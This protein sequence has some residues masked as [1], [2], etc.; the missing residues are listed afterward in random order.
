VGLDHEVQTR[1]PVLTFLFTDIEGHS[2]LWDQHPDAMSLALSEHDELIAS[3]IADGGGRVVKNAGDGAMAVFA[4]ADRAVAAAV[5]IQRALIARVWPDIGSLRVRMGLNAGS[6]ESR[7]GDFF[8]PEVIRAARL[9]S[10]ANASQIVAS[11]AVVE[12]AR[13]VTWLALGQHQL[14]GFAAPVEIHQVVA[15]GLDASFPA[16]RTVDAH[17]NTLPRFRTAFFG[18]DEEIAAVAELLSRHRLVTL[19][20][21]GG[22]GKTRLAVE[23]AHDQLG[24]YADGVFFADLS[25]VSETDRLWSAVAV[26]LEL[27]LGGAPGAAEEPGQRIARFLAERRALLV[28]DNCEHL[29]DAAADAADQLLDSTRHLRVLATSR[30]GLHLED[31]RMV[32][33]PSL[34]LETDAV[35]MFR[36]RAA[37][38]GEGAVEDEV[39]RDICARL[40]GLPLAIELAAARAGQLGAGEVARRLSDRFELLTGSRRRVPRQRTLEATL[41]WSHDHLSAEEQTA[42]R[43]L[44]VFNGTFSMR[45]AE[46]VT[47]AP[48]ALI[49]PLVDK[50]LVNRGDDGRFRLLETVRAYAE[51]RLVEADEAEM[52]RQAHLDWL[53]DEIGSFSDEEVLLATSDRSDEFVAA[54]MENLYAAL[55]WASGRHE[56]STVARL[57]TYMGLAEGLIGQDSFRPV[58]AVLRECLDNGIDGPLRDRALAGYTA[59]AYLRREAPRE[60]LLRE[61]AERS[62]DRPDGTAVAALTYTANMLDARSRARGDDPGIDLARRLIDTAAT[63]ARELGPQWQTLPVLFEVGLALSGSDWE[64]AAARADEL[65]G[66]RQQGLVGRVSDWALWVEAAA[67]LAV[68]RPLARDEIDRRL[69]TVRRRETSPGAEVHAR[70]F[71]APERTGPRQPMHLDR[72]GLDRSTPADETAVLISVA[73]LAAREGDWHVAAKLLAAGRGGG[74]IF[75]SVAGVALYRLTTPLVKEAL[76]KPVRDALIEEGRELGKSRAVGLAIDWLAM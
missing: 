26:G 7:D 61:A 63:Q 2:T 38:S 46:T 45:A 49:G 4:D 41:D 1:S 65:E 37:A 9:C 56:W 54:E 19:T 11:R 68:G 73:A 71:A 52:A 51:D 13:D 57:A 31:E 43:R 6:A 58:G 40:D 25:A 12:L 14:R 15:D 55:A 44:G 16:L 39:A 67:R 29:L 8:G 33:V 75:S 24:S 21:V 28:L 59:V 27:D 23:I 22:S 70:A 3:L 10:A 72:S 62:L 30:E 20:G 42:F 60:D 18:R 50:S 47:G 34:R 69:A 76:D 48:V 53:L 74:G 35:R 17:P 66:L 36:D 5:S 64:L 32:Q